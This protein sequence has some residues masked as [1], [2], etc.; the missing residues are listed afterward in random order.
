MWVEGRINSCWL[1][2]FFS[3]NSTRNNEGGLLGEGVEKAPIP[4]KVDQKG[5][6]RINE[7][8]ASSLP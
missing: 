7:K 6:A 5:A 1:F 2:R 4:P 8:P 3:T